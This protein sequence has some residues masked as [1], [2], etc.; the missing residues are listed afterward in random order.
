[1]PPK[2]E[3]K[4]VKAKTAQCKSTTA[5]EPK[6]PKLPASEDFQEGKDDREQQAE[7]SNV[8]TS[9]RQTHSKQK[10][11]LPINKDLEVAKLINPLP[12]HKPTPELKQG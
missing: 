10:T 4:K 8:V 6:L 9:T 1:M 3:E 11:A 7:K 12:L 2:K 5:P